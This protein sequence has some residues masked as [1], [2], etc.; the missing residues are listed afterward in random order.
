MYY[1][2][3]H[4]NDYRAHA[5]H[6]SLLEH[7]ILAWLTDTY[8]MT[9]QPLPIDEKKLHR[10]AMVKTKAEKQALKNVLEEFFVCT[11]SGWVN[12]AFD[13]EITAYQTKLLAQSENGKKGG[14][15]KKPSESQAEAEEIPSETQE[16]ANQNPSESQKKPNH[17]PITIN[18]K[19]NIKTYNAPAVA[20]APTHA[21]A[22]PS[23]AEA[24][25]IPS[26]TQEKAN[27][28]PKKAKPSKAD[29][30]KA[31][32]AKNG[33]TG[34]LADDYIAIRLAKN[35]PLTATAMEKLKREAAKA[36]LTLEQAITC[37][38]E[39]GWCGFEAS[40]LL[41]RV[42]GNSNNSNQTAQRT[43]NG[44]RLT[45]DYFQNANY[46]EGIQDI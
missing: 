44:N 15:P 17:K 23:Q 12:Q 3:R 27:T 4:I 41:N 46:G 42:F 7:G 11:E 5:A 39:H 21:N 13:E 25:E 32:L 43:T 9:E 29:A 10:L 38:T 31:L 34:Q 8:Y 36:G 20:D 37:S 6:L 14:R 26:E 19:P 35:A 45:D 1:Y 16:K 2:Q 22:K 18:H 28:K 33:I 24:E 40:W 30:W